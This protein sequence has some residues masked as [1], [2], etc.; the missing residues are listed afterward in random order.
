MAHHVIDGE[1][2]PFGVR[3]WGCGAG[4]HTCSQDLASA[5]R[6]DL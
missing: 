4:L 2:D 3:Q 5:P 1:I 6:R